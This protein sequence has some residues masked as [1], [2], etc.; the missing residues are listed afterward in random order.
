[1]TAEAT[2]RR[3]SPWWLLAPSLLFVLNFLAALS[4]HTDQSNLV[5]RLADVLGT[6]AVDLVLIAYALLAVRASNL[7]VRPTLA[8]NRVAL[9]WAAK[10]ALAVFLGLTVLD[11]VSEPLVHAGKKQGIAPT[12]SPTGQ[13]Q[14]IVLALALVAL[15][16]IA[17]IA[18][19]LIFRGLCFA[20]LGRS[21]LPVSAALFAVAHGL[22]V[23]LG[24]IF[25]AGLGIGWLRQRTGSLYPGLAVHM[26]LNATALAAALASS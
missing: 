18:E 15:V 12:H 23:L 17:P 19:E 20:A 26:A 5:Y 14:W 2:G 6:A 22:P 4:A 21:A 10:L 3:V 13:R 7:P 25:V 8:L 24:P 16:V 11:L 1:V 9:G